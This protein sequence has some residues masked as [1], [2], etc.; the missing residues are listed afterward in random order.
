MT[1]SKL[2]IILILEIMGKPAEYLKVALSDIIDKLSK[3]PGVSLINK[4]IAEPK[5]IT[6][7]KDVFS[8]F[9]EIEIAI[10]DIRTLTVL[11]FNYMPAHVEITNPES[12]IIKNYDLNVFF[13]ELVRRLHQYD[14]IA[15]ISL[16]E[17]TNMMN[18]IQTLQKQL[19]EKQGVKEKKIKEKK[20]KKK[21]N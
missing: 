7:E 18:H 5:L 3:E 10:N 16:M 19:E 4:K 6:G 11:M 15:K 1:E 20:P 9:A 13:N 8:S 17:R 21:K 14:E 12:L 2:D